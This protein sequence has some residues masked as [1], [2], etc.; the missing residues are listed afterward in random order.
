MAYGSAQL[1]AAAGARYTPCHSTPGS[2]VAGKKSYTLKNWLMIQFHTTELSQRKLRMLQN[3]DYLSKT[4]SHSV[5]QILA[6]CNLCLLDSSRSHASA[7]QVAEITGVRHHT[8]LTFVFLVEMGFCHVV[9][10]DLEL[11]VSRSPASAGLM[12]QNF[13]VVGLRHHF[14][15]HY[16]VVILNPDVCHDLDEVLRFGGIYLHHQPR[17]GNLGL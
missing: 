11:L 1:V 14:A 13:G 8:Q 10:A 9:Q 6:H 2:P 15:I 16:P 7:S 3:H 4:Q 5:A 12:S 17:A